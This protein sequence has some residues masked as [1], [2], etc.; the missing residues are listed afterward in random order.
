MTRY[1]SVPGLHKRTGVW[2]CCFSWN[3]FRPVVYFDPIVDLMHGGNALMFHEAAHARGKHILV[4]LL[5]LPTVI[6]YVWW[7]R[8]AEVIADVAAIKAYPEEMYAFCR[9]HPHPKTWW[10]RW[11]YARSPEERHERARNA[12]G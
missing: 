5:L 4:G 3:P 12:A 11:L 1:V 2:G 10:G 8:R 6:G 7:R 9:L